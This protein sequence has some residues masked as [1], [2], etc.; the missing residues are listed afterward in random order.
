MIR[1]AIVGLMLFSSVHCATAGKAPA[2]CPEPKPCASDSGFR[3][4]PPPLKADVPSR[5]TS[6]DFTLKALSADGKRVAFRVE[7]GI[8]GSAYEAFSF[9]PFKRV[10]R[11]IFEPDDAK[12]AWRAFRRRHKMTQKPV[13]EP[14]KPG[15]EYVLVAA[16]TD[17]WV[18]VYVM[19][20][21]KVAPYFKV[22]RLKDRKGRPAKVTIK[23][24]AWVPSGAFAIFIHN[25]SLKDPMPFKSDVV[26]VFPLWKYRVPF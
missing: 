11:Q 5:E 7:D 12:S 22:P 25:Q 17:D 10:A 2:K 3:E 8:A 14:Q 4:V 26:H 1:M 6:R 13:F 21:K 23:R 24:L 20:G 16:T 19:K 9:K 18:I 15:T